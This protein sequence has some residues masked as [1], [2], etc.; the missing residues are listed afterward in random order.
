M[1]EKVASNQDY[2]NFTCSSLTNSLVN[3]NFAHAERTR[4]CACVLTS[5]SP[6]TRQH[7]AGS[8]MT[9]GLGQ[10]SDWSTHR[11]VSDD[12]EPQSNSFN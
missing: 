5:G 3:K 12:N 2:D 4:Y 7:V 10:G 9:F 8:V 1:R 6:E 11:L